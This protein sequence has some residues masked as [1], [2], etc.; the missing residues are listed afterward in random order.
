MQR[1][2]STGLLLLSGI[3][4]V[5]ACEDGSSSANNPSVQQPDFDAG[6]QEGGTT[7]P[8]PGTGL[9]VS[10]VAAGKPTANVRVLFHDAA[11]AVIADTKT[12]ANGKVTAATAP[13]QMT[14]AI[15]PIGLPDQQRFTLVTY[16]GIEAGDS[17]T[18]DL[19]MSTDPLPSLGYEVTLGA[20]VPNTE[21]YHS[22]ANGS[23]DVLQ[24]TDELTKILPISSRC[25]RPNNSLLVIARDTAGLALAFGWQ[26]KIPAPAGP[27]DPIS[28]GSFAEPTN[29]GITTTNVPP[30]TDVAIVGAATLT[31][32]ASAKPEGGISSVVGSS[33]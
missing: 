18:F 19:S 30:G 28:I 24:G 29:V 3:A 12:D 23:C 33:S 14:L 32:I 11:G 7:N 16:A 15:A 5:V 22:I 4:A 13:S 1:A 21:V 17:L 10:V 9:V 2:S 8:P 20:T 25:V 6:S 26:K 31:W 27:Q